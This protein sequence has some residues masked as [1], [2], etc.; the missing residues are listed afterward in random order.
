MSVKPS[1]RCAALALL[2]S[3]LALPLASCG[4]KAKSEPESTSAPAQATSQKNGPASQSA[5]PV[6]AAPSAP[7]SAAEPAKS[8]DASPAPKTSTSDADAPRSVVER[9]MTALKE[10]RFDDAIALCDPNA[11]GT[12]KLRD[13]TANLPK[14]REQMGEANY[15]TVI[16]A[17]TGPLREVKWSVVS[18]DGDRAIV[19]YTGPRDDD[20][21]AQF[22]VRRIKGVWLVAPPAQ[23]MPLPKRK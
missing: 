9:Y 14:V 19:A 15:T 8:T 18:V 17:L 21:E 2:A 10:A 22:E 6:D 3:V 7:V 5:V 11:E 20:E 13:M 16:N 23:G 1:M 12:F 4:G